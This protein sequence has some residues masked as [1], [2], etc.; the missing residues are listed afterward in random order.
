MAVN[1]ALTGQGGLEA[2]MERGLSAET[3][4]RVTV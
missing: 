3:E 1:G 4:S 2:P